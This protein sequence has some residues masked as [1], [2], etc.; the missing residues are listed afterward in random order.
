[1]SSWVALLYLAKVR[2]LAFKTSNQHTPDT[3]LHHNAAC[4]A[5]KWPIS[6]YLSDSFKT[7]SLKESKAPAF[8]PEFKCNPVTH[9]I[10]F[11]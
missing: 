3:Q 5:L 2:I 7:W 4:K 1:M 11:V 9:L 10:H 8:G 6:I